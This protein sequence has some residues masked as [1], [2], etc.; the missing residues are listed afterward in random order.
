[1]TV[2]SPAESAFATPCRATLLLVN[3]EHRPVRSPYRMHRVDEVP[4]QLRRRTLTVRAF[5][6]D[7]MMVGW[8]LV[9][10]RDL[11]PAIARLLALP[12]AA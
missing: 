9:D 12:R 3:H 1:M 2:A 10:G 11:E 8:E 6:E 7:A 5:D 4:E